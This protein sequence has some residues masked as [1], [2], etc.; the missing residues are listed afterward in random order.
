LRAWKQD[1]GAEGL[2]IGFGL[3]EG[4]AELGG[5]ALA[6]VHEG[7]P[8]STPRRPS[9]VQSTKVLAWMMKASSVDWRSARTE[10]MRSFWTTALTTVVFSS[11]REVRFAAAFVVEQQVHHGG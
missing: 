10:R 3:G 4:F 9:P 1:G 2:L 8:A 11:Q 6:S 5:L 7:A